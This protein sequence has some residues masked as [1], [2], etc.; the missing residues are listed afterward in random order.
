MAGDNPELQ[1]RAISKSTKYNTLGSSFS[2]SVCLSIGVSRLHCRPQQ[3]NYRELHKLSFS[4][5]FHQLALLCPCFSLPP[6]GRSLTLSPPPGTIY[7]KIQGCLSHES[8]V[9]SLTHSSTFPTR[10]TFPIT[11]ITNTE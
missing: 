8:Q 4:K 3:V 10:T 11:K 7:G 5:P 2:P 1:N 6:P 9:T